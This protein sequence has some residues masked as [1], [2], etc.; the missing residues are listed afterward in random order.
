VTAK[1]ILFAEDQISTREALTKL[2]TMRGY[3]V[4]AVTNGVDLLAV[5][6]DQQ[7]DLVI[8]DLVMPDMNGATATE[9][10]KLQ[11]STTPVIALT[12]L[13]HQDIHLVQTEF[14]KIFHKPI[15]VDKLFEYIESLLGK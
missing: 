14:T 15:N 12:G 1:R 10:M 6:K 4:V 13:S 2:A 9:I 7:F 5:A 11:G 3:E 8:T